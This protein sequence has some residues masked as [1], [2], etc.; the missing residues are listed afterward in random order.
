MSC[1]SVY[2]PFSCNT[3]VVRSYYSFYNKKPLLQKRDRV[4]FLLLQ[5]RNKC[6]DFFLCFT[7]LTNKAAKLFSILISN[8]ARNPIYIHLLAYFNKLIAVYMNKGKF[9]KLLFNFWQNW[10]NKTAITTPFC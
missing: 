3:S 6:L 9:V 7:V 8:K 1:A 2:C 10:F 5:T 4:L